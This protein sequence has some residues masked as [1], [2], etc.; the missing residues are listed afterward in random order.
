MLHSAI[1]KQKKNKL[2]LECIVNQSVNQFIY[3][4]I[5]ARQQKFNNN[6]TI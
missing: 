4:A 2:E 5:C 3:F 6:K 1:N